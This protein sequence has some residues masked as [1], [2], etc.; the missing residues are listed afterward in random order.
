VLSSA[1]SIAQ[2]DQP[3]GGV[4]LGYDFHITDE[5]PQLIEINTNAGGALLNVEMIRAQQVCC[6]EV[7]RHLGARI[8][9]GEIENLLFEMFQTEW[10][11][12]RRVAP[13]KTVAIVD[14]DPPTQYLFPEFL[15]FQKLFK[16]HGVDALFVDPK[17]LRHEHGAVLHGKTRID[18]IYNRQTDFYFAN[19]MNAPL[20]EA[21]LNNAVVITPHP[22][23]HALY[24]NKLNL[25]VL[26]DSDAMRAM[27][28]QR[29]TIEVLLKGIPRTL[30]VDKADEDRWWTDRKRWFFKPSSGFGSRGTYRGDKMTRK[31]FA[32]VMQ[33]NYVAQQFAPPS[34]RWQAKDSALKF[35][36]RCY[37]YDGKTQLMAARLYQGQTTNFRTQGGGFAPVYVMPNADSLVT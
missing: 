11:L 25:A 16:T 9:S 7:K 12:S 21:Y 3:T 19:D 17:E 6:E 1:P 28:F 10:R 30:A 26:T 37:V 23:A 29:D 13:L 18:L 34:E 36:I 20:R 24:A 4:F 14:V 35:D 15:L 27:G 22:R 2:I 5:G 32:D 8:S 33:G 31:A